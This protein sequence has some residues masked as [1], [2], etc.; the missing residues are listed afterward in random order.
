MPVTGGVVL[1][2]APVYKHLGGTMSVAGTLSTDVVFRCQAASSACLALRKS[3]LAKVELPLPGR[4]R[5]AVACMRA[6]L[7]YLSGTWCELSA[8]AQEKF[9]VEYV[10]PLRALLGLHRP[11]PDDGCEHL[12]SPRPR[13]FAC[14][15]WPCRRLCFWPRGWPLRFGSLLARSPTSPRSC[16][17]LAEMRGVPRLLA[18]ASSCGPSCPGSWVTCLMR[19]STP[20]LGSVRGG[21]RPALD[22]RW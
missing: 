14:W 9:N 17:L 7:C 20:G 4:L 21:A 22:R 3:C 2:I 6:R 11:P 13:C 10:R 18:V 19:R 1:R 12:R 16:G 15:R 5:T 8:S